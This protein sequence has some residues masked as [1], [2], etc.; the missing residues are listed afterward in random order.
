MARTTHMTSV[1]P[2]TNKVIFVKRSIVLQ[3]QLR[4]IEAIEFEQNVTESNEFSDEEY[5]LIKSVK[6][7][8]IKIGL[9]S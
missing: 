7:R 2:S 5:F 6:I 3:K 1:Q 4:E 9:R 8:E